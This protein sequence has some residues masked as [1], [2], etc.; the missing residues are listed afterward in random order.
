[1]PRV[2]W[3]RRHRLRGAIGQWG[4]DVRYAFGGPSGLVLADIFRPDI[5]FCDLLMPG[6]DGCEFVRQMRLNPNLG[7]AYVVAVTARDSDQDRREAHEAGF[8][9]YLVKPV[10]P[11]YIKSVLQNLAL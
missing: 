7:S 1:L 2:G 4:H 3:D 9:Q 11:E 5:V 6:M 8:Q 10:E